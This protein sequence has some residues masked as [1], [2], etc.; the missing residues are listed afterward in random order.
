[1]CDHG[2]IDPTL[3]PET[4][5]FPDSCQVSLILPDTQLLDKK[6]GTVI[7]LRDVVTKKYRVQLADETTVA[8]WGRA[9]VEVNEEQLK[10][11]DQ[12]KWPVQLHENQ[13]SKEREYAGND[14]AGRHKSLPTRPYIST[15]RP[16]LLA[17]AALGT[18][19]AK[20]LHLHHLN[21]VNVSA[22]PVH[23][24][25]TPTGSTQLRQRLQK[26]QLSTPGARTPLKQANSLRC[27]F[28][29]HSFIRHPS[30]LLQ[31][32]RSQIIHSYS[33]RARHFRRAFVKPSRCW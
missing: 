2:I 18:S 8:A 13:N 30:T 24:A 6:D 25:A 26:A 32:P 3:H 17:A 7:G 15:R 5:T 4:A 1:V 33:S 19:D 27:T 16:Q 22:A 11:I 31:H 21:S 20:P 9:I 14:K 28:S 23:R 10:W 12:S 29:L